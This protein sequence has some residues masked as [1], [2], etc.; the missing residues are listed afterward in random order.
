MTS[1]LSLT[2]RTWLES[3]INFIPVPAS[4]SGME[5][6]SY[7]T[8]YPLSPAK[9]IIGI[10]TH[11]TIAISLFI[12][13]PHSLPEV[14]SNGPKPHRRN[15]LR[16]TKI[17]QPLKHTLKGRNRGMARVARPTQAFRAEQ[18][19]HSSVRLQYLGILVSIRSAQA[20]MP[21][22]R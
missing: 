20:L 14:R 4:A 16:V 12:A 17:H 1:P 2:S 3:M 10:A 5:P 13:A 19:S 6:P 15:E 22:V 9:T 11:K 18:G 21:P 7:V 8:L